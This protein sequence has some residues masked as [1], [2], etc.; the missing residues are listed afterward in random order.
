MNYETNEDTVT[1]EAQ[2][3]IAKT[4]DPRLK[5]VLEALVRHTHAFVKEIEP[6][7][8][9]ALARCWPLIDHCLHHWHCCLVTH[10]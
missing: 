10:L 5:Q 8:V 3:R 6:N 4:D 2:A 9:L 1:A 7:E